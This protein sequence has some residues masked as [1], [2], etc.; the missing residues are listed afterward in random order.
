MNWTKYPSL[1]NHYCSR[2]ALASDHM[3][4]PWSLMSLFCHS[5]SVSKPNS[6]RSPVSTVCALAVCI[7]FCKSRWLLSGDAL[8][9][10]YV[11]VYHAG[12]Q[13]FWPTDARQWRSLNMMLRI[14]S[15]NRAKAT[16]AVISRRKNGNKQLIC[17]LSVPQKHRLYDTHSVDVNSVARIRSKMRDRE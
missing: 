7:H 5:P 6:T 1:V 8:S 11:Y 4:G 16:I 10:F 9:P 17:A 3:G 15:R 12:A 13:T 14:R 2:V